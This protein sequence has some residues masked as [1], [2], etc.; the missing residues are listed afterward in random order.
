MAS[1]APPPGAAPRPS[2]I[3]SL[4]VAAVVG[5]L[6]VLMAHHPMILTGLRRVQTDPGD[7]RFN[8][9]ILEHGYLW[10]VGAPH[11]ADFW[12]PPF[13]Y[14]ARNVAAYSD[15]LLSVAPIYAAIRALGC[16]PDTAF[17]AWMIAVSALN[18]L[19]A[20]H[21]LRRR[22]RLG[23][24]AS[25]AGAF[26]FAFGAPRVNQMGHQQLLPHFPTLVAIDALF[27][28]FPARGAPAW[29]R[30]G[31]WLAAALGVVAQLYA[32]FYLGWFLLLVLGIT[33]VAALMDPSTRGPFLDVL[34]RDAAFLAGAAALAYLL[35]RPMIAHYLVA[36]REA[37]MR[38]FIEIRTYMPDWTALFKLGRASWLYGWLDWPGSRPGANE[39]EQ[40]LGV[41]LVT[42]LC[43]AVGFY[44]YRRDPMVRLILA[45]ALV[46][47]LCI[48]PMPRDAMLGLA[49][50]S[51]LL[52]VVGGFHLPDR[53]RARLLIPALV[54]ASVMLNAFPSEAVT[55]VGLFTL[56]VAAIDACRDGVG[57]RQRLILAALAL[58]LGLALFTTAVLVFGSGL[59]A[60]A[61]C[62][63]A[64]LGARPRRAGMVALAGLLL[65]A[66]LTSYGHRPV[67]LAIGGSAP[68]LLAATRPIRRLPSVGTLVNVLIV[69]LVGTVFYRVGDSGWYTLYYLVPGASALRAVGRGGLMLLI[70]WSIGLGLFVEAMLSRG[71]PYVAAV[72]LLCLLEQ[73]MTTGSY[74]KGE[75]RA[76]VAALA[77]RVDR[78]DAAFYYSPRDASIPGY[79]YHLDAMWAG[80]EVGVP[81]LNGYS[82]HYPR[83]WG[84]IGAANVEDECEFP[85]LELALIRWAGERGLP[86]EGVGWVGGPS[87]W[88]QRRVAAARQP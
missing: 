17:Q 68:L 56:V 36:S 82:G 8:N 11:H 84:P 23:A 46:L 85:C 43:C 51:A 10:F 3:A 32:G 47:F 74:D 58:G 14:P 50:A 45:V 88:R 16:P 40:R 21:L 27:G 2:R 20:Y 44:R 65:F 81:T 22:L 77:R 75:N 70:A 1:P 19:A 34:R 26:L 15:L 5:A 25:C 33:A 73:G 9:Y 76:A 12:S 83:G 66:V 42:I 6:G 57:P 38:Y 72:A 41:G 64:V 80:L 60:L 78:R 53:P 29:R 86:L 69:A 4:G 24:P 28:L 63:A 39:G 55:G 35:L 71:R 37:G 30:A 62:A 48:S 54:L 13:C 87:G 67:V 59:G 31:L 49:L 7:T 52:A 18:Y 79:R 61:G